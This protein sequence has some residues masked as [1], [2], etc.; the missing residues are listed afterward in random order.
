MGRA[1]LTRAQRSFLRI[2]HADGSGLQLIEF[3]FVTGGQEIK[4]SILVEF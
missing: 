4:I 2:M 1:S 3:D